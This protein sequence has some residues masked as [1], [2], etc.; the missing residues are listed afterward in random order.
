MYVMVLVMFHYQHLK[1]SK[2]SIAVKSLAEVMSNRKFEHNKKATPLEGEAIP[3]KARMQPAYQSKKINLNYF[4]TVGVCYF[5][6]APKSDPAGN[7]VSNIVMYSCT[8][9]TTT[10]ELV[11]W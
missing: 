4:D 3:N 9:V 2:E 11:E 1:T 8:T 5:K 10:A 6:T 7:Y